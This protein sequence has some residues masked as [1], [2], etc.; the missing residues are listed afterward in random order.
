MTKSNYTQL[1]SL[2]EK[3]VKNGL[4]VLAFPCNQFGKQEPGSNAEIE[5]FA[6]DMGV[7]FDMYAKIDVNGENAHSL[8]KY[9]KNQ[10]NVHGFLTN[11]IKWNFTKF[12]IDKTGKPVKR[13]G[14][15]E[16]PIS[17]E[18]DIKSLL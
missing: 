12:L 9:L 3:Y 10:K 8:Y 17:M 14:P 6:T 15:K 16:S 7:K 11:D 1:E 5:K 4:R 13:F 2:Y 18:D